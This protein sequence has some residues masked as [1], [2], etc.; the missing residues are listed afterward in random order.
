MVLT[1]FPASSSPIKNVQR[2]VAV[3]SGNITITSVNTGKTTVK[4][5]STGSA[6]TVAPSGNIAAYNGAS[7]GRSYNTSYGYAT[8]NSSSAGTASTVPTSAYNYAIAYAPRYG[9]TY[10]IGITNSALGGSYLSLANNGFYSNLENLTFNSTNLSGGTT[11]LVSAQYGAYLT[12]S[13]TITVT[14]PCRYEV[15][16]YY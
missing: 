6:G 4:S 8:G 1:T 13:T 12:D 7:S 15:I 2:G 9:T 5:F 10:G 11:N 14:G 3:A 16:E